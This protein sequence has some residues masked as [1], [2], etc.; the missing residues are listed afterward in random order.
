MTSYGNIATL[1]SI[2]KSAVTLEVTNHFRNKILTVRKNPEGPEL[3]K[4]GHQH[5]HQVTK[6]VT[7][8]GNLVAK[9]YANLALS[10]RLRQVPIE[11]PL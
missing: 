2:L 9:N 6:M 7:K 1:A 10:P 11:S 5:D 8:V 3:T 4:I